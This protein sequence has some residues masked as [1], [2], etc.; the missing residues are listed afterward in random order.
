M[1]MSSRV[2][3][4]A[5]CIPKRVI[6]KHINVKPD[7]DCDGLITAMSMCLY[8]TVILKVGCNYMTLNVRD[9]IGEDWFTSLTYKTLALIVPHC[10][11]DAM[12][13]M[14]VPTV[15]IPRV[16]GVMEALEACL[17]MK[18]NDLWHPSAN[19]AIL[20]DFVCTPPMQFWDTRD[21]TGF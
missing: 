14:R 15:T 6:E 9:P 19:S 1:R 8:N 5:A 16:V 17:N 18:I 12:W 2:R 13:E 4:A 20:I 11:L 7:V 21:V 10:L 3:Y